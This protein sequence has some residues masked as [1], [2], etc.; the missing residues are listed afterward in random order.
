M[1]AIVFAAFFVTLFLT[2]NLVKQ[3][4][5]YYLIFGTLLYANRILI[6]STLVLSYYE[7]FDGDRA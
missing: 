4:P 3:I 7:F 2:P 6:G 1:N 5:Y